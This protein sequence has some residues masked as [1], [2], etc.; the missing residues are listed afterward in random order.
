MVKSNPENK[1]KKKK[2]KSGDAASPDPTDEKLCTIT[3]NKI[4]RTTNTDA[5]KIMNKKAE[6]PLNEE[7][8]LSVCEKEEKSPEMEEKEKE[9]KKRAKC[10]IGT[11]PPLDEEAIIPPFACLEPELDSPVEIALA[12]LDDMNCPIITPWSISHLGMD[13]TGTTSL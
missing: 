12:P 4:S 11:L 6:R 3:I 1:N 5:E 9:K 13:F 2:K 10:S 7:D 8:M